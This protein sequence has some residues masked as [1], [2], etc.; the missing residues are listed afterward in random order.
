MTDLEFSTVEIALKSKPAQTLL[1]WES[2][3]ELYFLVLGDVP[4]VYVPAIVRWIVTECKVWRPTT[5]QVY[6]FCQKINGR[7]TIQGAHVVREVRDAIREFGV[8]A[9]PNPARP[10]TTIEGPPPTLS[11]A[12]K[13]FV[14]FRGGWVQLCT[15]Q[16]RS[17]EFY[18]KQCIEDATEAC[19]QI[20]IE[21]AQRSAIKLERRQEISA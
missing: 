20:R 4:S 18:F 11:E 8:N 21:K 17:E 19:E 7:T 12:A 5:D 1:D 3:R 6:D 14:E 16:F 15:E 2:V 9:M 10:S 13:R